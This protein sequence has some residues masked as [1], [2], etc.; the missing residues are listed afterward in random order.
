MASW[1]W[2]RRRRWRRWRRRR[3]PRRRRWRRRRRWPRR[4]RRRWPRRR[5]RRRPAR[6]L[7]R[8]RRRRRVRRP[9]RRQKLILTQWNPQTVRKCVI[10]GFLPLFN[11]SRT[12]Y[13]RNFVDHMDDVYPTGP[14]GGGTG[15]ML[16]NLAF[17][18]QEFK[19]HHCKWSASNR[20][21]DL[22]R[23]RGT[24]LKFYRH[25]DVDYIV[26]LN[27][28]PPFQENLLDAMSRQ[29]LA[30]LQAHK[31]LLIKSFKTHPKG[32]PYV[33]M[34]VRPPR[35]L[36][37]KW[38]FQPDFCNVPLF[39]LHFALAELRFPIGSPQTANT[40]VNFLVL[41]NI[42][43]NF[44]DNKP[45]QS[46]NNQRKERS[47]GYSFNGTEGDQDRN[48]L[49]QGL[50]STGRYLNT[51]HI[52]T[53]FPSI[54]KLN[55][56]KQEET[57]A[58]PKYKN[59]LDGNKKVYNDSQYRQPIWNQSKINTLYNA[60]ADEQY[61]KIQQYYNTTYGQY[62]TQLFT[63]KKYWDYRVGMFSPTFLSPTRLNPEM[64]GAYTE[65]A[66]NPWTD[67]GTG[68]VVCLQYLTKENSEYKPHGGSKFCVEDVPLWLALNGYV[69]ICKKEG[70]DP[71]IRLNCLM[72]IRCPYTRP[73]LY[74]PRDNTELFVVYSYNF[75][76]GRMP[77]GEKY[78]PM[79][80]KDRWYP[81]LMHQE[82]V[83]ED[84]VR[85]GPFALKDQTEMVTCMMRYSALF[86][87][88]GNIIREQ[89]VEDPCKKGTFAVPGTSGIA[90]I[91][92][93][94][95]P[96]KQ[97]PSTTWHSWD[98]RRSLFTQTGLKR[99][100][101]Q[102]PYDEITYAGPKRPKLTVPAGPTLAAGDAY[103]YWE[104]KPLTSPAETLPSQT[105]TETEAPE[106]ELQEEEVPEGLQL[107]ELWDQQLQ[108]KRQ[109]G[110]VFQQLLRL[111]TGAEIHP[112]LA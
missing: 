20:D 112:A 64:P 32:P 65:V 106:E 15:S 86:N 23:Y 94:S 13:H 93:V 49:W 74:N 81:S 90:R 44:L 99:M 78:I 6:R 105:E 31:C 61:R 27:R 102:Q 36:T 8:R 26:W 41:D 11:C 109:L 101:E 50:W 67:E 80:F 69:D 55:E 48:I 47:H 54:S 25:L 5:R 45:K 88:G 103:N 4:R 51:P 35:L 92:Q 42:Y 46:A 29:P 9:R 100:R 56:H 107:R 2:G 1:W 33:R 52:N 34:K 76:H 91:L 17:F 75:G 43:Y 98:W 10:R 68:N 72:C 108:Q 19:K 66:Y 111:R 30:M 85:S 16:F 40:C 79:E 84:I 73:K 62:Q 58:D 22:C 28:T 63:G 14:C 82:E 18:Y 71:G 21:F 7:R 87:W 77:G 95:N 39:Q 38:Y 110:I 24:V 37:D 104:R 57:T 97:T 59:L 3:L 12:A 60:I 53:L 70:K 83:I 89:A 96:L